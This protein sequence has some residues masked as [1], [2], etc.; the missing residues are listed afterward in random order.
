M[1]FFLTGPR[2]FPLK[3]FRG[4]ASLPQHSGSCQLSPTTARISGRFLVELSVALAR[5]FVSFYRE[6]AEA[7]AL[8]LLSEN[9][10]GFPENY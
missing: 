4:D 7:F 1:R 8:P 2:P 9:R 3:G 6:R 5:M 10:H